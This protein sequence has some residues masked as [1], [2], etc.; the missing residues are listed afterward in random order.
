VKIPWTPDWHDEV[1]EILQSKTLELRHE[2]GMD[3]R[4]ETQVIRCSI[5]TTKGWCLKG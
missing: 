3:D 4:N 2:G 5:E 1:V